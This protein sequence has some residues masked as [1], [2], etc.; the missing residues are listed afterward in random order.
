MD[1]AL[2]RGQAGFRVINAAVCDINQLI[3]MVN[4]FGNTIEY[5]T[6]IE[7]E[8][9]F[10]TATNISNSAYNIY[11]YSNYS[12]F[13]DLAPINPTVPHYSFRQPKT[14]KSFERG[15]L[16][17]RSVYDA[18]ATLKEKTTLK[19][20]SNQDLKINIYPLQ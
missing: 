16:L 13:P 14:D 8:S 18:N 1:F 3:P 2:L 19:Y 5:E 4:L 12:Q 9:Y 20:E 7:K 17:E 11:K 10:N 15:K 6:V